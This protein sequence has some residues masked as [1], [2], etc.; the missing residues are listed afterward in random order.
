MS[1]SEAILVLQKAR[2]IAGS[3]RFWGSRAEALR[4]AGIELDANLQDA[5]ILMHRVCPEERWLQRIEDVPP[6]RLYSH[7]FRQKGFQSR[8]ILDF[9]AAIDGLMQVV[10]SRRAQIGHAAAYDAQNWAGQS[11]AEKD[12]NFG[13]M[14]EKAAEEYSR[15]I[16]RPRRPSLHERLFK[17]PTED[18]TGKLIK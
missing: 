17:S 7:S 5:M 2:E 12:K 10:K 13:A 4:L 11:E 18:L 3:P 6:G 1:G 15:R 16:L 14:F 9:T 8:M